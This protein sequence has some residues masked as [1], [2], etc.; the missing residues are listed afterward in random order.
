MSAI[1][2]AI[3]AIESLDKGEKFTYTA[4]AKKFGVNRSTLS[5]THR[6]VTQ[7][8]AIKVVNQRKLNPQQEQELIYHIGEL[9]KQ[10]L[11]PGRPLIQKYASRIAQQP[12]SQSWVTRFLN[13]NTE[14]LI[15]K[16]TAGMDRNRHQADSGAKYSL[17]FELLHAKMAE[18][19]VEP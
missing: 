8:H 15:Y 4:I 17:Y 12:V 3:K 19:D 1:E 10:G 16:W 11:P 13:R 7:P 14:Q 18:Y 5:R 6:A 9:K 2:A